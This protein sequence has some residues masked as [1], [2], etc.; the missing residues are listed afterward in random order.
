[1]A[2]PQTVYDNPDFMSLSGSAL[3][4]LIDLSIQYNGSNNGDLTAAMSVMK[5]RGWKSKRGLTDAINELQ[6]ARLVIRTR[7]GRFKPRMC[8]LYAITWHSIDECV[9]KHLQVEPTRTPH[10]KFSMETARVYSSN[11]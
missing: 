7:E 1:M 11:K 3:R 8:A 6:E 2:I 4:L 5:K 10:R 9:G